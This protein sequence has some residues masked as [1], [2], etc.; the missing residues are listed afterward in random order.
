MVRIGKLIVVVALVALAVTQVGQLRSRL[1][2]MRSR[3]SVPTATVKRQDL[4]VGLTGQGMLEASRVFNV[5]VEDLEGTAVEVIKDGSMVKPGDVLLRMD[6]KEF[7]K[8][9]QEEEVNYAD[10]KAR[11]GQV[12]RDRTQ[13]AENS[14]QTATRA[15]EGLKILG[16]SNQVE[17][18]KSKAQLD[19]D[20]WQH[21]RATLDYDRQ[22]RLSR[23]GLVPRT[24]AEAA[25][26][27]VRS[28]EFGVWRSE[29]DLDLTNARHESG[30]RQQQDEIANAE[31]QAER[32]RGRIGEAVKSAEL[33][34]DQRRR[35]LERI[36]ENLRITTVKAPV[37]GLVVLGRTWSEEGRRT[38]RAGDRLHHG[39]VADICDLSSMQVKMRIDE[40]Q[41]GP[42]KVGQEC[43]VRFE[44][45]PGRTFRGEVTRISPLA[46]VVDR[47]EDASARPD[48][49]VFDV[50][51]AMRQF[52]PRVLRPG[53]DAEVQIVFERLR[54]V[55]TVPTTAL[56]ERA[57]GPM[58]YVRQGERF[59]GRSVKVGRRGEKQ[60][61]IKWGLQV[62]DVV[63][64]TDMAHVAAEE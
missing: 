47:W 39:K 32:A 2:A 43:I 57:G 56:Y 55:I 64:L 29:R 28:R 54:Q 26:A 36:R 4:I 41:I 3:V 42:V 50:I 60:A 63:A 19:Y 49:R 61:A 53:M 59:V 15:K 16:Q 1:L 38:I 24:D 58:V 30:L 37:G 27:R 13:D 48:Q 20:H 31:F 51:V 46:R 22:D 11:V 23:E 12:K 34:A 40:L 45:A 44:A 35:W 5:A 21:T 6:S 25:E 10:A 62:G 9:L 52:D 7:E 8:S 18:D 14:D 33:T 17:T